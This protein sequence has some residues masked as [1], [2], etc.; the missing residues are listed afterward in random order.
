MCVRVCGGGKR[1]GGLFY[2]SLMQ[3]TLSDG[4]F[5]GHSTHARYTL[6]TKP[7]LLSKRIVLFDLDTE[8]D[9]V[10]NDKELFKADQ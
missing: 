6:Y 7:T 5:E 2:R 1:G 4:V 9:N 3:T 10:Q 8:R